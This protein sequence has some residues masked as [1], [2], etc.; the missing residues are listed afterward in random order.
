[1]RLRG[2][3]EA[4]LLRECSLKLLVRK[5]DPGTLR[6]PVEEFDDASKGCDPPGVVGLRGWLRT[7]TQS[8]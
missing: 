2:I 7:Y 3:L 1:M 6:L 5:Q 8:T 4:S